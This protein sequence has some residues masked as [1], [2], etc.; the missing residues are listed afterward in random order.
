MCIFP[1]HM[2]VCSSHVTN[3][4]FALTRNNQYNL[5]YDDITDGFSP[6]AASLRVPYLLTTLHYLAALPI[7]HQTSHFNSCLSYS[8]MIAVLQSDNIALREAV[9]SM[10]IQVL[11][12]VY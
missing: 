8:Q 2:I 3:P 12:V 9:T 10:Q 11:L 4:Y 5:I 7:S 1:K 6:L